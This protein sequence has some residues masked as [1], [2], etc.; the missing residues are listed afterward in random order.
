MSKLESRLLVLVLILGLLTVMLSCSQKDNST[1]PISTTKVWLRAER[2]PTPVPGMAYELWASKVDVTAIANASEVQSAGQFSFMS[3][4]TLVAFLEPEKDSL[5]NDVV[6]ADSNLFVFEGDLFDYSYL[7]VAIEDLASTSGDPG[8]IMLVQE[9]TGASDTLRLRFPRHDSLFDATVRCCFETP[10][11]GNPFSQ[12]GYGLWFANYDAVQLVIIDTT[13][14]TIS[15]VWDTIQ[16]LIGEDGDTLNFASLYQAYPD[17]VWVEFDTVMINFGQ[18][19]LPLRLNGAFLYPDS[20]NLHHATADQNII[21]EVDST[22]PRIVKNY[23]N[24]IAYD[25]TA[26]FVHLDTYGQDMYG[27]PDLS[28]YGWRYKGWVVAD[29]IDPAA[30]GNFT[31]PAWDFITG[32][33]LIPGY[34]GGLLTTGTFTH[35]DQPDDHNPFTL[36]IEWEADSGTFIDTVLLRPSFPGEDFL[37]TAS[38]NA[39]TGGVYSGPINLLST[40]QGSVFVTMEPTNMVTDTTNFPLIAF[41][42]RYPNT[43][44]SGFYAVNGWWPLVNYTGSAT[45]AKGFPVVTAE[46]QG[47]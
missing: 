1:T 16:A 33:L 9:I 15:Y 11:D 12:D 4:D 39:A 26:K 43:I 22:I 8:P 10:T 35:I 7:F 46:I 45:G 42:F 23:D 20:M 41:C 31:P 6:R 2:L 5:G 21:Y 27:L 30:V 18:D 36:E 37:D 38:I 32:E 28:A 24:G 17:T 47:M 13:D 40:S 44:Y 29:G 19:S 34:Q 3:S 14:V 25:T